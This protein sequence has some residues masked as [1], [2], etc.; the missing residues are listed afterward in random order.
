M[1]LNYQIL[2][3]LI[4]KN[5]FNIDIHHVGLYR[6]LVYMRARAINI[7]FIFQQSSIHA[8]KSY[9]YIFYISI[10]MENIFLKIRVPMSATIF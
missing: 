7:Y 10:F 6:D 5:P 1:F 4:Y 8:C 2:I 9:T 3:L